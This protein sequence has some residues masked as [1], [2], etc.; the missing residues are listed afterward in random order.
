VLVGTYSSC[1]G[2]GDGGPSEKDSV[3]MVPSLNI[4]EINNAH[5]YCFEFYS[6]QGKS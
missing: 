6:F 4:F 1:C 5:T 2:A 3:L